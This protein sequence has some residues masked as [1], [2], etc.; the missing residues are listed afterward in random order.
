MLLPPPP[1]GYEDRNGAY[2]VHE[3]RPSPF[4]DYQLYEDNIFANSSR[5]AF[6]S[7]G[8]P[9]YYHIKAIPGNDDD[10]LKP[11]SAKT[12]SQIK[13]QDEDFSDPREKSNRYH[14]ND[15]AITISVD[16]C[17]ERS[18]EEWQCVISS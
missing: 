5:S 7:N 15:E 12:T 16:L 11:L 13:I 18:A 1:T 3:K 4:S 8:Y 14:Y 17:N 2:A 9:L 10:D 6:S